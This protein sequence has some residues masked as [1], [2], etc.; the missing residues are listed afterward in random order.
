VNLEQ[1]KQALKK[2]SF[3]KSGLDLFKKIK[4]LIN[5]NHK[6]SKSPRGGGIQ[7]PPQLPEYL[8]PYE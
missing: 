8:R 3:H 6:I 4:N 7:G 2:V 5:M 1:E